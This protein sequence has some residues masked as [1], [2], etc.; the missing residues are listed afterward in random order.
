MWGSRRGQASLIDVLIL[1]FSIS[2]ALIL[3]IYMGEGHIQAE[4][5]KEEAGYTQSMLLAAMNYKADAYGSYSNVYGITLAEAIDLF[6]CTDM[7]SETDLEAGLKYI[8]DKTVKPDYSYIFYFVSGSKV[9]HVYN[10][11]E[12]V[13]ARYIP[14]KTFDLKLSCEGNYTLPTLGIWPDWKDLPGECT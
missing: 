2:I 3:G 13:C 7:I 8:F 12:E 11:Q 6:A 10:K 9:L 1:G 4:I 14:I 5:T